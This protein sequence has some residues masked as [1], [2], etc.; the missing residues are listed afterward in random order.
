MKRALKAPLIGLGLG[1][2]ALGGATYVGGSTRCSEGRVVESL[3][4]CQSIVGAASANVC[5]SAFSAF[6][7]G[8]EQV[9]LTGAPPPAIADRAVF[10]TTQPNGAPTAQAVTR[11]AGDQKW[12]GTNGSPMEA[13]RN[14]CS[15]SSGS[16]TSSSRSSWS[17]YGGSGVNNSGASS[18]TSA[19]SA[20]SRGG[21]GSSGGF[22]SGS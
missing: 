12:R 20:V 7:P 1:A 5:A 17:S 22:S 19:V 2:T 11:A 16:S 9:S 21:F 8:A 6:S 13:F 14:G 10:L 18:G 3:A 4:Q 15:R